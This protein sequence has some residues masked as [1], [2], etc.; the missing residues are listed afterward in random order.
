[1]RPQHRHAEHRPVRSVTT[2]P[3]HT[4]YNTRMSRTTHACHTTQ[5]CHTP[6][7]C[8]ATTRS[9]P[10]RTAN[11]ATRVSR[12][13]RYAAL[14][15]AVV[16]GSTLIGYFCEN[17]SDVLAYKVRHRFSGSAE[18]AL[19]RCSFPVGSLAHCSC[20]P[21]VA[22]C[23]LHVAHRWLRGACC[24]SCLGARRGLQPRGMLAL[25]PDVAAQHNNNRRVA[26]R[27]M[28]APGA[29]LRGRARSSARASSTYSL[30]SSTWHS[31]S[32]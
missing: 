2:H 21:C 31:S 13:D 3:N 25:C 18:P 1:V 29:R 30:R 14:T 6:H 8:H 5:T 20:M 27:N 24:T 26:A 32:N 16:V 4:T 12:S 15:T 28:V 10:H 9:A 7:T 17:I 22:R 19:A 11:A 23:A